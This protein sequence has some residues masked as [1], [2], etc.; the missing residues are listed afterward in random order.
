MKKEVLVTTK[1]VLTLAGRDKAEDPIEVVTGG[2]YE[3]ADGLHHVRF[4]EFSGESTEKTDNHLVVGRHYAEMH[5]DGMISTDMIFEEGKT[6]FTHYSS[7]YGTLMMGI[8]TNDVHVRV[9]AD[10]LILQLKYSLSL[11]ESHVSDN[12]LTVKVVSKN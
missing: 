12:T 7:A 10:K 2:T 6:S 11:D 8:H 3:Y 4:T 1:G 9:W 5:K